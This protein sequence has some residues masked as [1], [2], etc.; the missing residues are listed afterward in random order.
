MFRFYLSE[1]SWLKNVFN[2]HHGKH[3]KISNYKKFNAEILFLIIVASIRNWQY[4]GKQI[5]QV[6]NY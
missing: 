4:L 3:M 6:L 1:T 5:I 2:F